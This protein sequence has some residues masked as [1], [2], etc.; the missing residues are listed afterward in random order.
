MGD[1]KLNISSIYSNIVQYYINNRTDVSS[2]ISFNSK[3]K[4]SEILSSY[5]KNKFII[6]S[7]YKPENKEFG[8][9]TSNSN[10]LYAF[11]Q[12]QNYV[13]LNFIKRLGSLKKI[14]IQ[15]VIL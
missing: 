3:P 8:E 1:G 12:I 10:K 14:L 7:F 2:K 5:M 15:I 6:P 11:N 9:S 4:I 13:S